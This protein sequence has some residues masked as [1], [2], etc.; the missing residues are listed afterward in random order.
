MRRG[1]RRPSTGRSQGTSRAEGD[2]TNSVEAEDEELLAD[3]RAG[4]PEAWAALWRRH[5]P[6]MRA[7]A[8]KHLGS[9]EDAEDVAS[10]ALVRTLSRFGVVGPPRSLSA[11]LLTVTR[12][13]SHD[14]VRRRVR[15]E[16]VVH[17]VATENRLAAGGRPDVHHDE[18][19]GFLDGRSA[20][21][22]ALTGIPARQRLV[23]VLLALEERTLAE[24]AEV[25]GLTPNATSQLAFRARRSMI[26][27]LT[28][29]PVTGRGRG[30]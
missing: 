14:T 27:A 5:Y 29:R 6:R 1:T 24:A 30:T 12:N 21:V 7:Y 2:D 9:V 11:Y 20:V 25:L 3:L 26:E 4:E 8:L 13:L 22:R 23:L 10:E 15:D 17:R 16:E 19:H 18:G 28:P